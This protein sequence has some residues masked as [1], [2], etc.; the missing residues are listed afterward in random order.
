MIT[1]ARSKSLSLFFSAE[2]ERRAS[3]MSPPIFDTSAKLAD[4]LRDH[5]AELEARI[6]A[7]TDSPPKLSVYDVIRVLSGK[8][9]SES[10][11]AWAHMV[12]LHP[13]VLCGISAHKFPGRGQQNTPTGTEADI[14]R[15]VQLLPGAD[16]ARARAG[17][18][19]IG[20]KDKMADD[21][22]IMRYTGILQ[23]VVKIGRSTN[24]EKRRVSL[25][26][27][28]DFGVELVAV[29]PGRGYLE[30]LVHGRFEGYRSGRGPG[31]EWFKVDA[32]KALDMVRDIMQEYGA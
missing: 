5:P 2:Q 6:R 15:V 13:E 21:L 12:D 22:Y 1:R 28:Q 29:F 10:R 11:R 31:T 32:S 16:M 9:R 8:S 4:Y 17:L 25:E 3:H 23:D 30:S 26:R 27:C 14:A 20:K 19:P 7:T 18:Q 24:P